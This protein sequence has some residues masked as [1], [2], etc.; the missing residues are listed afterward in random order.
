MKSPIELVKCDDAPESKSHWARLLSF[1]I[2][3]HLTHSAESTPCA[4]LCGHLF[5]DSTQPCTVQYLS[6]AASCEI[7]RSLVVWGVRKRDG[8]DLNVFKP[9]AL[10][11]IASRS[12]SSFPRLTQ[13]SLDWRCVL[14]EG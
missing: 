11:T 10:Q 2:P 6:F 4:P 13:S 8:T 9:A 12:Q 14:G 1:L 7:R 5:N 3:L